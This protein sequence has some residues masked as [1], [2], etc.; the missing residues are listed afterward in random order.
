MSMKK[1]R[2]KNSLQN[3][4]ISK[5]FRNRIHSYLT[6]LVTSLDIWIFNENVQRQNRH[7]YEVSQ[8]LRFKSKKMVFVE[9][10]CNMHGF[11]NFFFYL[12]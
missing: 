9:K 4:E 12:L 3:K 8:R 11:Y 1:T 5:D 7:R 2:Q 6:A 10:C